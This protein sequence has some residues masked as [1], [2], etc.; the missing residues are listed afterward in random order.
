MAGLKNKDII[1]EIIESA[2][3][4]KSKPSSLI[5]RKVEE[6]IQVKEQSKEDVIQRE[7]KIEEGVHKTT[8]KITKIHVKDKR[9]A[10]YPRNGN[11]DARDKCGHCGRQP[12]GHHEQCPTWDHV[13]FKCG[14][15]GH[16]KAVC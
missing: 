3:V 14:S 15:T 1:R 5:L 12:H 7:G 6:L 16:L 2:A 10:P 9:S 13:C 8:N 11:S 4:K